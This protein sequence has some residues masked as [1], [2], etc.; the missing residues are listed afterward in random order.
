[1]ANSNMV[2]ITTKYVHSKPLPLTKRGGHTDKPTRGDPSINKKWNT[3]LS[4]VAHFRESLIKEGISGKAAE[5]M[6]N[7]RRKGT[8]SAYDS[9][10]KKWGLWCS[11]RNVDP[12]RCNLT[13]VLDF[14]SHLFEKGLEY[15]TIGVYRSAISTSHHPIGGLNVG[16]HP[17]VCELMKGVGNLKPPKPKFE[18][19]W[20]VSQV[21][22][23]L[24]SLPDKKD[25]DL[26]NLTHKLTTSL[27]LMEVK[28]V[29]ELHSLDLS[30]MTKYENYYVFY[31]DTTVK[32]SKKGK[33]PPP[34]E[35]HSIPEEGRICPVNALNHYIEVTK[36]FRK[37]NGVKSLLLSVHRP[38]KA[39]TKSTVANWIKKVL[40]NS[41][42]DTQIYQAHSIRSASSSAASVGGVSISDILARGNWSNK[43]TREKFYHKEIVPSSKR[44][45]QGL[46]KR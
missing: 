45:Q 14:L 31:L 4:S 3:G 7:A 17:Q 43:N 28:R 42:I 23:Y 13:F 5:L 46:L 16:K 44:Y 32:H 39:I 36:P 24:K 25:L 1:M 10:W 9:S 35:F 20:D 21:L 18:K 19:I 6:S 15:R 34:I 11:E 12:F 29:L 38:H 41:G 8:L 22:D 26:K 40:S 33:V 37:E 30:F 2:P 27:G